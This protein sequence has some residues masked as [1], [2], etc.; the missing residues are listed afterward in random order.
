M[1]RPRCTR[2]ISESDEREQ[3]RQ[4]IRPLQWSIEL[5]ADVDIRAHPR[6]TSGK[7]SFG[8]HGT[9]SHGCARQTVRPSL[10]SISQALAGEAVD[11][12]LLGLMFDV[13]E[14]T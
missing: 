3:L 13:R 12:K 11:P 2:R 4:S 9:Q 1:A 6:L 8:D 10:H 5:Q 7:T 14:I